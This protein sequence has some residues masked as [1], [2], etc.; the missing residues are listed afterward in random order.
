MGLISAFVLVGVRRVIPTLF[1]A[2]LGILL[3]CYAFFGK[4][5]A[6]LGVAPIFVGELMLLFAVIAALASGSLPVLMR[7]GITWL[8]LAW[9][10]WGAVR[11]VPFIA[12]YGTD[13]LRDG[14]LWG[15]S[16]FALAVAACVL[17][18]RS[19]F[20]VASQYGRWVTRFAAWLPSR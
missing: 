7:G 10:L 1:L 14:A 9:S 8:M 13:A 11:T 15:Y 2:S 17:S 16:V 5:F 4:S 20:S 6:Y 18:T 12:T 19:V 3:A